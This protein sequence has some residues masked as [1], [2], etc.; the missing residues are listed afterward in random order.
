MGNEYCHLVMC[1]CE[2]VYVQWTSNC[3]EH[4]GFGFM[5]GL[6]TGLLTCR[7]SSANAFGHSKSQLEQPALHLL[8]VSQPL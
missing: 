7:G 5:Q 2:R 4:S 6:L 3:I 8:L 1:L